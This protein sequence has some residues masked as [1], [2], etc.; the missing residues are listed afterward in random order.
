MIF[1]DSYV[2]ILPGNTMGLT[3]KTGRIAG[4]NALKYIKPVVII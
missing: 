3:T 1:G 4:E 2:F